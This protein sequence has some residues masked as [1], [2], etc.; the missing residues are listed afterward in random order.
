MLSIGWRDREL[1]ISTGLGFYSL[2]SLA[3]EVAQSHVSFGS[4]YVHLNRIVVS[5]YACS[6]VY[7]VICFARKE[8]ERRPFTPQMQSFL[9]GLSGSARSARLALY[10][11]G[12]SQT[13]VHDR[14][15]P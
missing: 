15:S 8:P 4:L 12:Q 6:L 13:K 10:G 14:E 5:S 9:L 1:Q 7:S 3:V 2:V 11:S